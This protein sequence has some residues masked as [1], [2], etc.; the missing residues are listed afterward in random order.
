MAGTEVVKRLV[1]GCDGH[2]VKVW[3]DGKY[4]RPDGRPVSAQFAIY[5]VFAVDFAGAEMYEI[6]GGE[7]MDLTTDLALAKPWC[8]GSVKWDGCT[9]YVIDDEG[10]MMH[11]HGRDGIKGRGDALVAAYDMAAEMLGGVDG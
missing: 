9:N 10:V 8:A 6:P 5:E 2:T 7:P 4:E 1:V 11:D 3:S